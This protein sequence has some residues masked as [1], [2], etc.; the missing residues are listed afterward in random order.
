MKK[1]GLIILVL[2]GIVLLFDM[3]LMPLYTTQGRSERVPNVVGMEFEDAERKLEMAGFEAVRSY[4]AGYEVDVPA[5]VVLSQTPEATM[6]VKPGRAVYVVVNRGAKP[7]VQMPNFLGLS[8]G[9]A[10]QEAAR[11]ELFPVDVVG[12]PVANSS[13]DGRVLNQSLPAMTLVQSGM[14]LTLFVGRYDAEAVN[15]E[16]IELPNLLGMSLGQAQQTL[17]E[18]GLIIGHVVTERSRLLLPNTVISQRPAVGTLLAPGQAVD[19]TIVG[20]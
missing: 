5:N 16:R 6:E 20:E 9:E 1:A 13:D 8:E 4:N 19:L 10:R 17:A 7:A 12:T 3:L 15:A 18:A 14:P 11:L 2:C